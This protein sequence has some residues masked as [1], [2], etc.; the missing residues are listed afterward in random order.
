MALILCCV[1]CAVFVCIKLPLFPQGHSNVKLQLAATFCVSNLIWNEEDGKR[2]SMQAEG[3]MENVTGFEGMND[4]DLT[5]QII[6][7]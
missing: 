4:A 6:S 1:C 7:E 5:D 3:V 2:C